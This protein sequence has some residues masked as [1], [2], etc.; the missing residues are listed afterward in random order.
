VSYRYLPIPSVR[1]FM[2]PNDPFL[3]FFFESS[4]SLSSSSMVSPP[5]PP[6]SC[7]IHSVHNT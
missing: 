1:T 5:P 3:P 2:G 7:R 4:S 6:D